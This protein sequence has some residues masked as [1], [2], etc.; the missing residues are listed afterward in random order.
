VDAKQM[1]VAVDAAIEDQ[2][3]HV[4]DPE[5]DYEAGY[6]DGLI[7]ALDIVQAKARGLTTGAESE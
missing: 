7:R 2:S 4:G 3:Q 6:L 1:V 5:E